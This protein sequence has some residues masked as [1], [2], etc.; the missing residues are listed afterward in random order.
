[1]L[2]GFFCLLIGTLN[3]SFGLWFLSN[4]TESIL[5]NC[6]ILSSL[7]R[8]QT[9]SA[10]SGSEL[11]GC[12][13]SMYPLAPLT[14]PLFLYLLIMWFEVII[15]GAPSLKRIKVGSCPVLVI[16]SFSETFGALGLFVHL[17]LASE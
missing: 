15:T 16:G 12:M 13:L 9:T 1:M 2:N 6:P 14:I 3:G 5:N 7:N 17:S 11:L 8:T 4:A 10:T